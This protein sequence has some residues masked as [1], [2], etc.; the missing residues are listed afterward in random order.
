MIKLYVVVPAKVEEL[1]IIQPEGILKVDV[2][3]TVI[4]FP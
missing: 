3:V 1:W 4:V 2:T